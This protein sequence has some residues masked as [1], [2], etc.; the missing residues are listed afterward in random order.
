[1]VLVSLKKPQSE[2]LNMSNSRV[3]SFVPAGSVMDEVK[4][5]CA[6]CP[7]AL[8]PMAGIKI[9]CKLKTS[10]SDAL[11]NGELHV[12]ARLQPVL[13][14]YIILQCVDP[15]GTVRQ[16]CS[17]SVGLLSASFSATP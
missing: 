9:G 4:R 8:C 1:M 16:A 11:A 14:C 7:L 2:V 12:H 17:C 6:C 10:L 13:Y 3:I 5:S 15:I